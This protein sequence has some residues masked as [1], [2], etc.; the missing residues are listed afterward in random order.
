MVKKSPKSL[1][2]PD[3]LKNPKHEVSPDNLFKNHYASWQFNKIDMDGKW[4]L[5][6]MVNRITFHCDDFL[7]ENL[8]SDI[9]NRILDAI[10]TLTGRSFKSLDNFLRDLIHECT[11]DISTSQLR[12]I[13]KSIGKTHFWAKVM[14]KL[15]DFEK[16]NWFE[17]ERH[18]HDK[19]KSKHH[20]VQVSNLIPAAQKRLQELS[21]DDYGELF[22]MT[23]M[24]TLRI[25]G[26]RNQ[27]Y[28]TIIWIDPDHEIYKMSY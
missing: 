24:N 23:L 12:T 9:D 16:F 11:I 7:L 26:I 17:L 13:I 8:P 28:L 10:T 20:V 4:G 6:N 22:S 19:S 18:T 2:Q 5:D 15:Q 1:L 14:P 25:Y 27:G 3:T 21:L